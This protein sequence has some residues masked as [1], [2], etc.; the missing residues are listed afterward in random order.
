MLACGSFFLN[1]DY[2]DFGH[3]LHTDWLRRYCVVSRT[4]LR[5]LA[6]LCFFAVNLRAAR[7][8]ISAY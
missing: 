8:D 2:T 6:L 7:S 3:R 4:T 5:N 1:T